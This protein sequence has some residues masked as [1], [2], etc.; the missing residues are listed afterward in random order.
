MRLQAL[1]RRNSEEGAENDDAGYGRRICYEAIGGAGSRI[2]SCPRQSS[3]LSASERQIGKVLPSTPSFRFRVNQ[4]LTIGFAC[5]TLPTCSALNAEP[6]TALDLPTAPTAMWTW[7]TNVLNRTRVRRSRSV[8]GCQ[9][10]PQSGVS[11]G[12]D[13]KLFTGGPRTKDKL[14]LGLALQ[15]LSISSIGWCFCLEEGFSS[16]GASNT[17]YRGGSS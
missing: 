6:N 7:Y 9:C 4:A 10:F 11:T 2:V 14:A 3:R 17:I 15:S 5:G 12:M 8:T 1:G 13:E 16:G